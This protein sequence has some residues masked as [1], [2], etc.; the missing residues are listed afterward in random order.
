MSTLS[1]VREVIID[2]Q[3]KI[4]AAAIQ[5]GVP[6]IIPSDYSI[7]YTRLPHGNN[8]NLDLRREFATL[9]DGSN[10]KATS[11]LNGMFTDLLNDQAP[12]ILEKYNRIFFWGNPDQKMDFTTIKNTAQY[13]AE[14]ALDN[15]TP[16]WLR[17]AGE[18]ASMRDIK[19]IATKTWHKE[20][21]FLRPGGLK[22]FQ[23]LIAITKAMA[24]EKKQAFPAWQGMQYLHDML[25]GIP[26][27]AELD[28]D[29]YP[30][31]SWDSIS[32]VLK[33]S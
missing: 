3:S 24:P 27:H 29:R 10:I 18:E 33:K 8:R 9:V 16:R 31:I 13:T 14:A 23:G 21:N 28:N 20:F 4:V 1:G 6:R 7:D 17:I 32:S 26:K 12:V 11:I 2:T 22:V 25:T 5:A 19:D 30:G 15:T